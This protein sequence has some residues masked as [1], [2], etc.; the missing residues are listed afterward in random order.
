MDNIKWAAIMEV[1]YRYLPPD[2]LITEN[3]R[4]VWLKRLENLQPALYN[5]LLHPLRDEHFKQGSICE[6]I[7]RIKTPAFIIAGMADTYS[8]NIEKTLQGLS[9]PKRALIGPWVALYPN[10]AVP[11]PR[12]DFC[13]E[14]TKW[15]DR[16]LKGKEPSEEEPKFLL[17]LQ[18]R[19]PANPRAEHVDGEWICDPKTEPKIYH[20]GE[21][22]LGDNNGD[23]KVSFCTKETVGFSSGGTTLPTKLADLP[24]EQSADDMESCY[25]ETEP[26]SED[27]SFCGNPVVH[28]SVA[29]DRPV[30]SVFV[31]LCKV[32]KAG[33]SLLLSYTAC[34]LTHDA[35]HET[36]APLLPG[37]F[38]E[39]EIKL[40]ILSEIINKGSRLRLCFTTALFP[41][42]VPNP[43]H[44]TLTL[45]L[46]KCSLKMP[47][48]TNYT[49][50]NQPMIEPNNPD[51][52][53]TT[54][55][56]KPYDERSVIEDGSTGRKTLLRR[57]STGQSRIDSHGLITELKSDTK[58]S[59]LPD[60]PT[61]LH[62]Q[63][64]HQAVW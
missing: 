28:V 13:T 26:F 61:S 48:L 11:G 46:S 27:T 14:A 17:Y 44:T 10:Q 35:S 43:Q 21:G 39:V 41:L 31:R 24:E 59:L 18:N 53:P 4:E 9:C 23:E 25:F 34:N 32:N 63:L 54:S 12:W 51:P 8:N 2:P 38:K 19:D 40:D 16:W 60:D 52:S 29:S 33:E 56:S 62:V 15:W 50:Y 7:Q 3:W 49:T 55:L 30:A 20:L 57:Q 47:L 36:V 45:D 37:D 42:F 5:W 58:E 6:D 22:K 64:N 1:R